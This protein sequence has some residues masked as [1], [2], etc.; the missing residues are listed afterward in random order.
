MHNGMH[1]G[2]T[3][4][5]RPKD[6]ADLLGVSRSTLY[7]WAKN[8]PSFPARIQIGPRSTGWFLHE[9]LSWLEARRDAA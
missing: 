6:A 8:D 3:K 1:N 2:D 5:L 4:I 7:H 9:L